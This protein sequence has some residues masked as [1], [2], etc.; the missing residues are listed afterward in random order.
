MTG[1]RRRTAEKAT[2]RAAS[3]ASSAVDDRRTKSPVVG[4]SSGIGRTILSE[5]QTVG[6]LR[7]GSIG[8]GAGTLATYGRPGDLFRVYEL[9]P[10]VL[11]IAESQFTYLGDS[12]ARVESV[13]GDARLSLE[14]EIAQDAFDRPEQRFDVLSLDA[15][16]GDAIPVHLLT[17]EAFV[18]Y[19]R[20]TKPD[21]VIAFHLSNRYLDLAPVVEQIARHSGFHAVLVAD[22]PRGQD[23]SASDWVLVTRNIAFL[24]QPEIAAHSSRIVP[25]SGLPVWTD[26]FTNLFQIL[27]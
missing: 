22:R 21:G 5:H 26:E 24:R 25:R 10:A 6:P 18:T 11:H 17:S 7:I 8:L 19:T 16:S 13:L 14:H 1:E 9:N 2:V 15:F 3:V 23:V 27:K 12:K 20:V 4:E